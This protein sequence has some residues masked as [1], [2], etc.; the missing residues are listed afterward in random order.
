M[1][2]TGAQLLVQAL[3]DQG[4]D[5]VFG[6]PGGTVLNIYDALYDEGDR[7]RH[8]LSSHEQGAAHMADGY[9]RSTGRAGVVLATSG[10]GATNLITGI[11]TAYL[12]SV[13]L[14]A[15]TG[16]V[17][18]DLIGRD[19]FQEVNSIALTST[20]VKR[21][22]FVRSPGEIPEIVRK[23]FVIANSGRKGPVHID[24]P[25]D[26]TALKAEY[27]KAPAFRPR[28]I[29]APDSV[30]I[31][32]ARDA[33]R[34]AERPL[35]Y[36]GGGVVFS[37]ASKTLA[38]F[39]AKI[40]SPVCVSMMGLSAMSREYPLYLGM[41]G[42]HGTPTANMATRECDTLIVAGA[43][44]S[45]R[46]A[47]NRARFAPGA[48]VVHIDI[49]DAEIS[50]NVAADIGIVGDVGVVLGALGDGLERSRNDAWN[51]RI[52]GSKAQN[53]LPVGADNKVT[54]HA[55][56]GELRRMLPPDGIVATDVG[57]HQMFTAQ[58]FQFS[59][60][61]TFLSSCGL[62]TMGYGL[63][64]AIGAKVGN[65][66]RRVALVTGDGCF[67]MNM[68]ELAAAVS[69]GIPLVV[70]VMNNRV[71]GM[72]HQWQTLFYNKRYSATEMDRKTDY[73]RLAEAFGA[74]GLRIGSQEDI[75]PTLA[76]AFEC[77]GPCVVDCPVDFNERV[78]PIIPPGGT[79]ADIIYCDM[80]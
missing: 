51:H 1:L 41:V 77:D 53:A 5:V 37:D 19:S 35:I 23:A 28:P 71:L 21:N 69:L 70:L 16:N 20:I 56:L 49:D 18:T 12:D 36:A 32:E 72:V 68:N 73:V 26:V 79:S 58:H 3:I 62:G 43:R 30:A 42:M 78:Y 33:V 31:A 65:P 67:H 59:R 7:I 13:P 54:P 29:P 40:D 34:R 25:K 44:F 47:G 64:A 9:A 75:R 48:K 76:R 60:P 52:L 4:V 46:V 55:I 11:A 15:V 24:I 38:D 10:P 74:T 22:Y 50:K 2:M 39:A 57:Q 17:A 27:R 45:D 6:Y 80:D 63:G 14:I 8:I 61:R 66:D